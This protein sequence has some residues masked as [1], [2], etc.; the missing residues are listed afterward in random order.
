MEFMSDK[1]KLKVLLDES[2]EE[3]ELLWKETG[4]IDPETGKMWLTPRMEQE[5]VAL[6]KSLSEEYD[7]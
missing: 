3:L 2:E 4:G 6:D 1:E 5:A 7:T